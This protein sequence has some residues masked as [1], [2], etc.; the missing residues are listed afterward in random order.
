MAWVSTEHAVE[1]D[2]PF[3]RLSHQVIAFGDPNGLALAA[4][5]APDRADA[6]GA[7]GSALPRRGNALLCFLTRPAIRGFDAVT[8]CVEA[9]ERFGGAFSHGRALATV[10]LEPVSVNIRTNL[11]PRTR[12]P[13]GKSSARPETAGAFLATPADFRATETVLSRVCGCKAAESQRLFRPRQ[14]TAFARDC[15]VGLVGLK[16]ATNR[17][18]A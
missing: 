10:R 5:G 18:W 8:L 7:V 14:E 17:L 13:P 3:E 11:C 16:P 9:P 12:S 2:G 15:V 4:L 1:F 6:P